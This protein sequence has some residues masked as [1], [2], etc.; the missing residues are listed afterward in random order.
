MRIIP[1]NRQTIALVVLLV[2]LGV[3][4][5]AARS[6]FKVASPAQAATFNTEYT[7][8]LS[9]Y[10]GH[11]VHLYDYSRTV[12]IAYAWASWCPYCSGELSDLAA[13]KKTYGDTVAIVAINRAE[14]LA[15]AKAFTDHIPNGDGLVYLLDP[16]DSFFKEIGG[17]AMPEMV[18]INGRGDIVF[19][20]RG[21]IQLPAVQAEIDKLL[22]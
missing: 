15:V 1:S 12:L 5:F 4:V 6:F 14:P 9:D 17:Y 13:L 2:L 20:Q 8:V 16:H 7:L 10:S 3:S 21:P 11:Q 22:H 18:F 19:H